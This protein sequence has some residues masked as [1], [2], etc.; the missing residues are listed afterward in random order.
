MSTNVEGFFRGLSERMWKENDLSDVTYALCVGNVEFRQFFLDFFFR[1]AN[2]CATEVDISRE[3]CD[4]EGNR[5]D[6][7]IRGKDGKHFFV[8]VKLWDGNLHFESYSKG[9]QSLNGDVECAENLAYI[10]AY[11]IDVNVVPGCNSIHTWYDFYKEL[12]Q[13]KE[14]ELEQRPF[15]NDSVIKGYCGYIHAVAGLHDETQ[16]ESDIG[17][18]Q[19]FIANDF[20]KVR[21]FMGSL[22]EAIEKAN[23]VVEYTRSSRCFRR[24]CRMGRFFEVKNF[25]DGHSVWGWIGAYY[26]Y[27]NNGD[28]EICVWFED[29]PGWG[30]LVCDKFRDKYSGDKPEADTWYYKGEGGHLYFYMLDTDKDI[31]TFFNRV[32]EKIRSDN[33]SSCKLE[34]AKVKETY[35][36]LLSMRRFPLWIERNFFNNLQIDDCVVIVDAGGDSEDPYNHC[37]R[38]FT[39]EKQLKQ[40]CGG[41]KQQLK[42]WIGVLFGE[43]ENAIEKPRIEVQFLQENGKYECEKCLSECGSD[44][45]SSITSEFQK[46]V[47]NIARVLWSRNEINLQEQEIM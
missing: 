34:I 30:K 25:K 26:N 20:V 42:G 23:D 10:A 47:K 37:G 39:V 5:P 19:S 4:G 38:Y 24:G 17:N 11:K 22:G 21:E 9:L 2:L 40:N 3:W 18:Y 33:I 32:L 36:P 44:K 1:K 7:C 16:A 31:L 14:K 6:F 41:K 43:N 12:E 13:Y 35:E 28:P 45:M 8:E 46:T 15:L 27:G 29:R